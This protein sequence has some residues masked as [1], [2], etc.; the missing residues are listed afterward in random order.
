MIW[1]GKRVVEILDLAKEMANRLTGDREGKPV[2]LA[3][4]VRGEGRRVFIGSRD[5]CCAF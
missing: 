2:R 3:W 5:G 4:S 1:G